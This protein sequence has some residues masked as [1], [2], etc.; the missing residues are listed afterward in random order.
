MKKMSC[1]GAGSKQGY[2]VSKKVN[3]ASRNRLGRGLRVKEPVWG[4]VRIKGEPNRF[5]GVYKGVGPFFL[6]FPDFFLPL[7]LLSLQ[8]LSTFL[9]L[10]RWRDG[11]KE[12]RRGGRRVITAAPPCRS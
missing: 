12:F 5:E 2:A 3:W 1:W 6:H 4:P 10:L 7:S 8:P 11:W 9:H